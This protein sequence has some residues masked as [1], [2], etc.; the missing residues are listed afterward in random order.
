MGCELNGKTLAIIGLGRIGREVAV[1]MKSYGMKVGI[2]F[3]IEPAVVHRDVW[4]GGVVGITCP[5]FPT[6]QESWSKVSHPARELSKVFSV[7]LYF[8][9]ELVVKAPPP[10]E[11]VLAHHWMSTV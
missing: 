11:G 3:I 9:S 7:T 4:M 5:T 10:T 6:L 2:E 8:F 1:R